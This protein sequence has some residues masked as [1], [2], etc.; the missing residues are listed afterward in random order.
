MQP[1]RHRTVSSRVACRRI[2]L[3]PAAT[4]READLAKC[5]ID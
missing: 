4:Q 2:I 5:F 1:S 3:G